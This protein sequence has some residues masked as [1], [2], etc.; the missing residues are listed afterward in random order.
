MGSRRDGRGESSRGEMARDDS[1]D[2]YSSNDQFYLVMALGFALGEG[3]YGEVYRGV[4][5]GRLVAL[6]VIPFRGDTSDPFKKQFN[7]E[8]L[9]VS[10]Q[11]IPEIEI[12]RALSY[13]RDGTQNR[14]EG[15]IELVDVK[16]AKTGKSEN[17]SPD[18][19]SS[20]DQFYLV[21]ALEFAGQD[22]EH[23]KVC[24]F[25][26]NFPNLRPLV[27]EYN[28]LTDTF[29]ACMS[30]TMHAVTCKLYPEP[31][32]EPTAA[33]IVDIADRS[34]R[35]SRNRIHSYTNTVREHYRSWLFQ[36]HP[37]FIRQAV[38]HIIHQWNL[39][40]VEEIPVQL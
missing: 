14:T 25:I 10:S 30:S 11:L 31:H 36:Q 17:D 40:P 4:Y 7:G 22:L 28:K 9:P 6:K 13:L 18:A 23:F 37:H 1:P 15:F 32:P 16:F 39:F 20:N 33:T 24:S 21:M 26:L 2:A 12:T 34:L 27:L 35:T 19:Y 8:P 3:A 29:V 5:N 38:T